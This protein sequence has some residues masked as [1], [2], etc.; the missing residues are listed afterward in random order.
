[1][2]IRGTYK[3]VGLVLGISGVATV[4]LLVFTFG[5]ISEIG[6]EDNSIFVEAYDTHVEIDFSPK[7]EMFA[8]YD[9]TKKIPLEI[10]TAASVDIPL[11]DGAS[12]VYGTGAKEPE[13]RNV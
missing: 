4:S 9:M 13:I 2:K 8:Y 5:S 11:P 12:R 7:A 1:M 10:I 6:S 3:S